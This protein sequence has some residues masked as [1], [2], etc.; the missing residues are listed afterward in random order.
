VEL[1]G[2]KLVRWSAEDV[3]PANDPESVAEIERMGLPKL[4]PVGEAL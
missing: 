2:K 4:K 3:V 1:P